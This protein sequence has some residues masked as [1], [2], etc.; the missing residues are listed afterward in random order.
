MNFVLQA[1]KSLKVTGRLGFVVKNK[2]EKNI[3]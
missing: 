2:G 1:D 3:N